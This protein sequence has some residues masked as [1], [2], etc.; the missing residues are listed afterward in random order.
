MPGPTEQPPGLPGWERWTSLE[1]VVDVVGPR[2][3]GTLV[4]AAGGRLHLV[5]PDGTSSPFGTFTTDPGPAGYI[6]M[7]PGLDVTGAACRFPEGEIFALEPVGQSQAV[8]RVA[9]DGQASRFVETPPTDRLTG[10][11]FDAT[12][13]FGY[14]LLV[15]GRRG[16]RTV[17]FGV[18]CRGRLRTVA[19][20]APPIEGG[21][22]VATQMFGQHGGDLIGVDEVSGD[23]VF[24]RFDGTNGVLINPGLPA[25]PQLGL[26]GV[27]FIPVDF[28]RRDGTAYVADPGT[29]ALWRIT[30]E[31][32]SRVA[33]DEN[34][35]IVATQSGHTVVVRC[36]TTCRA[37]PMADAPGAWFQGHIP[38][39]LGPEPPEPPRAGRTGTA[40][41]AVSTL[42]II[43]GG[44]VLFFIHNRRNVRAREPDRL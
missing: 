25:G 11:A 5:R 31:A 15:S 24:I 42:V 23:V 2:P 18:D 3:D 35:M 9:L 40:M 10:I 6:A 32:F 41:L 38:V 13:R 33:I 19:D 37:M 26:G 17:V 20:S 27:G 1:A 43:A 29:S 28:I 39:V 44:F 36:R 7:A 16:D 12:G 4:A 30:P 34:D 22:A 21:M 8:V 14:Q